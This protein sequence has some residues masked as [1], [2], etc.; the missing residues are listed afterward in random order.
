MSVYLQSLIRSPLVR[1]PFLAF[2]KIGKRLGRTPSVG[3]R[4]T[5]GV[6]SLSHPGDWNYKLREWFSACGIMGEP[7]LSTKVFGQSFDRTTLLE[8]VREGPRCSSTLDG[9]VKLAWEFARSHHF[10]INSFLLG[11]SVAPQLTGEMHELMASPP[12]SPFWS[13]PMDVAIRAVNWVVADALLGGAL[14]RSAP[15]AG[16]AWQHLDVIWRGLEAF[17]LSGNHYLANLLGLLVLGRSLPDNPLAKKCL[18]FAKREWP[19]ALLAQTYDDGGVCEASLRYHALVTEMALLARLF[20]EEEWPP[21]ALNRLR[22]MVQV[23]AD[24]L[25]AGG[26]VFAVGDDDSGRVIAAD[27]S[28]SRGRAECLLE[29]AAQILGE[30][31]SP[32]ETAL[33]PQS[34]WWTQR[35]GD[36][37][38]HLEFGGVGMWGAGAHAHD[39]DLAVCLSFRNQPVLVD[40]GSYIYTPDVTARDR[41]RSACN[42]ST[43]RLLPRNQEPLALKGESVFVWKG[44]LESLGAE[45]TSLGVRVKAGDICREVSLTETQFIV[46]DSISPGISAT[47]W[48]FFHLHPDVTVSLQEGLAVLAVRGMKFALEFNPPLVITPVQS[49]FAPCYGTC[50]PSTVLTAR[51]DLSAVTQVTWRIT[52]Q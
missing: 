44:R 39:D 47:A 7:L 8:V 1:E 22:L 2:R 14:S 19:Q 29:L 23:V 36:W 52:M 21:A 35:R 17:R 15:F 51:L 40:P 38:S 45:R 43:I 27:F 26:D 25:D 32:R 3:P 10:P 16:W 48:W 18:S 37:H 9:D 33:Y 13:C 6:Q 11:E 31:F 28:S 46:T 50:E 12:Q 30:R 4:Q 34:G 42:H 24:H 20:V 5:S 49:G 41:F